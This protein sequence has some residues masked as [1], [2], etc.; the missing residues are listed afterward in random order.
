[1]NNYTAEDGLD[2]LTYLG[3]LNLTKQEKEVFREKW[4]GV[5]A[6]R[7]GRLIGATWTLYA[8]VLPFICRDGDAN[9]GA[10]IVKTRRDADFSQRLEES[11]LE[12]KLE[13]GVLLQ[14]IFDESPERFARLN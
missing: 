11:P 13:E 12:K 5:Y 14:Q 9:R 8:E 10:F 6:M 4:D 2:V 3:I 7:S 1:M